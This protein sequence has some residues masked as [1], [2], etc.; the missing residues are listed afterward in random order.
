MQDRYIRASKE[1][2]R[3][4]IDGKN[5]KLFLPYNRAIFLGASI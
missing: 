1:I 4:I 2:K 3:Q 5:K